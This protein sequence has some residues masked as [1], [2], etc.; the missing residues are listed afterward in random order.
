MH[1]AEP[2]QLV[3]AVEILAV[4]SRIA[5][6]GA[7]N[8]VEHLIGKGVRRLQLGQNGHQRVLAG[9]CRG[10]VG[11]GAGNEDVAATAAGDGAVAAAADQQAVARHAD[12]GMTGIMPTP[13]LCRV[14]KRTPQ[15]SADEIN[16]DA[17]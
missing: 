14:V 16:L 17:A 13:V 7:M 8:D 11:G 3:P 1:G 6:V 4:G 2:G 10:I 15:N 12:L 9:R 5:R